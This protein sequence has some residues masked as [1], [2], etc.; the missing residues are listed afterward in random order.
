MNGTRKLTS[1][2]KAKVMRTDDHYILDRITQHIFP[3]L[4]LVAFSH[5]NLQ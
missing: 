3:A 5:L 2:L 1:L 4:G